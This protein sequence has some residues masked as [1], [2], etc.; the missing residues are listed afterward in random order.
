MMTINEILSELLR[1]PKNPSSFLRHLLFLQVET[2]PFRLEFLRWDSLS[3]RYSV[4]SEW[5]PWNS[6]SLPDNS[7]ESSAFRNTNS[8]SHW[9]IKT[10]FVFSLLGY[11]SDASNFSNSSISAIRI[12][13]SQIPSRTEHV[14]EGFPKSSFILRFPVCEEVLV[15]S[16]IAIVFYRI[17]PPL[18]IRSRLQQ[19]GWCLF[20]SSTYSSFCNSACVWLIQCSCSTIPWQFFTTL[21]KF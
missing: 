13:S 6:Q 7:A 2:L 11:M 18:I 17:R 4:A 19:Y 16:Q 3:L 5:G 8:P 12:S 20:F 10:S 1:E 9:V 21:A 14:L 15:I